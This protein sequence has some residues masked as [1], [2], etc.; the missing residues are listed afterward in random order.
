[1]YFALVH[2]AAE[3]AAGHDDDREEALQL[4]EGALLDLFT[5]GQGRHRAPRS[6]S[7]RRRT[8]SDRGA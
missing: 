8:A 1:M 6:T 5:P 4:M 7:R 3:H 2:G